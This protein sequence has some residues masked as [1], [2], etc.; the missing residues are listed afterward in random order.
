M[1]YSFA[2]STESSPHQQLQKIIDL[3]KDDLPQEAIAQL[4]QGEDE[5]IPD[6]RAAEDAQGFMLLGRAYFYAE[7]DAEAFEAFE[8]ALL[9]DRSLSRAHFFVGLLQKYAG[10]LGSAEQSFRNAIDLNEQDEDSFIELGRTLQAK[11]DLSGAS[12]AYENALLLDRS[13]VEISLELAIVYAQLGDTANAERYFLTAIAQNPDHIDANYNLGQLYQSTQQHRL[14]IERFQHVIKLTPNDWRA[15]SKLVQE[16]EA[17]GDIPARDMAIEKI[18]AVWRSNLSDDFI[19]QGFYI[20]E[21]TQ[22]E[23]GKLFVLEYLELK[24]E[25]PRKYVFSLV[26]E[27]TGEVKFDVSLGSYETT[28]DAAK[29]M[30]TIGPDER[31][32]HIDGYAPNGNHYTYGFFDSMPSYESTREIALNAFEGKQGIVSQT[33]IAD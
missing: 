21:Q 25:R 33:V 31:L 17:L 1:N 3:F 24:G 14:A 26:D 11:G 28:N 18:Y 9:L 6:I 2:D 20:R 22:V 16:N 7:M 12:A 4:Q 5:W 10:D 13:S 19:E 23:Q 15:I 32:F 29:S 27:Q 8:A 30:G